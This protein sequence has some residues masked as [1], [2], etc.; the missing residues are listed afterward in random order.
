MLR[1]CGDLDASCDN[2]GRLIPTR[3]IYSTFTY[4]CNLDMTL[5]VGKYTSP[6]DP[7]WDM[8]MIF[9]QQKQSKNPNG[10]DSLTGNL[11][12]LIRFFHFVAK[13]ANFK[14]SEAKKST[15]WTNPMKSYIDLDLCIFVGYD[16]T[17]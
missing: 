11:L 5:Q 6:M 7:S 2:N 4:I 16:S 12:L 13:K 1:T 3:S 17:F 9:F 8:D 15:A 14:S 10:V